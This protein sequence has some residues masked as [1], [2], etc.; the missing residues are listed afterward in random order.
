MDAHLLNNRYQILKKLGEGGFGTT[1][2]AEDTLMPSRRRCVI[3]QLK[4]L[5]NDPQ[6]YQLIRPLAELR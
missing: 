1:Y 3:K 4:P 6:I 2:L 5:D